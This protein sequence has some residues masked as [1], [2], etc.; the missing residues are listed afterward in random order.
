MNITRIAL[1][2]SYFHEKEG[3]PCDYFFYVFLGAKGR[4]AQQLSDMDESEDDDDDDDDEPEPPV[5]GAYLLFFLSLS[6]SL[7]LSLFNE[8]ISHTL[9][10]I[11]LDIPTT[12]TT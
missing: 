9:H 1:I 10:A 4:A 3:S 5:L 7:C 2:N 12:L 11:Y 6:L 8:W